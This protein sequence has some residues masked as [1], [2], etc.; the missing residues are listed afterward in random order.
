MVGVL[1]RRDS[2]ADRCT[3]FADHHKFT[4]GADRL[5]IPIGLGGMVNHAPDA[6]LERIERGGGVVLRTT[7]P[8]AAG[9]EL[10]FAYSA[11][12]RISSWAKTRV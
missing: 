7:R 1:V 8:V 2:V 11:A 9:E 6:N 12:A 10:V 5:L 3:R 4:V